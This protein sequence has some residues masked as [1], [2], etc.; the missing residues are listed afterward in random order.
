MYNL[1]RASEVNFPGEDVLDEA[2]KFS[3]KYLRERRAKEDVFDKW[4]MTKDLQGEVRIF[5]RIYSSVSLCFLARV[6]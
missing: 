2:A 3:G 1:Y 5:S 4:I 6:Y